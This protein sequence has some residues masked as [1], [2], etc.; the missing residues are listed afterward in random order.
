MCIA[1]LVLLTDSHKVNPFTIQQKPN[2]T[3]KRI[4]YSSMEKRS[5]MMLCLL[6][7]TTVEY[8]SNEKNILYSINFIFLDFRKENTQVPLK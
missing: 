7:D 2:F 8:K 3:S 5:Y 1:S 4:H 6:I